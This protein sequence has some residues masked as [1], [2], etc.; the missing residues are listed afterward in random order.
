MTSTAHDSALQRLHAGR[1][2]Q[3]RLSERCDAAIATT[4][5]RGAHTGLLSVRF[6]RGG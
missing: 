3:D 4:T 5:E 1:V 2:E 6:S